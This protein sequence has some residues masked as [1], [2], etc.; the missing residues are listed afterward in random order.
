MLNKQMND[1]SFD[2]SC[3]NDNSN[4]HVCVMSTFI[5]CSGAKTNFK[6]WKCMILND[7]IQLGKFLSALCD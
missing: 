3:L 4:L 2:D 5:Y 1:I 6:S 7:K